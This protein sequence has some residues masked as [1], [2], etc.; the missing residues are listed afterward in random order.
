MAGCPEINRG[1]CQVEHPLTGY[2]GAIGSGP[3]SR[4]T[5]PAARPP[6]RRANQPTHRPASWAVWLV[7]RGS[8]PSAARRPASL[9][10]RAVFVNGWSGVGVGRRPSMLKC[11]PWD[12]GTDGRDEERWRMG[13]SGRHA[14]LGD[15]GRV[16]DGVS[17]VAKPGRDSRITVTRPRVSHLAVP[18]GPSGRPERG[19]HQGRLGQ[20]WVMTGWQVGIGTV[21]GSRAQSKV[22]RRSVRP[23]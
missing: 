22:C 23:G 18:D 21:P 15:L 10:Q 13:R 12:V 6:R 5:C 8:P 3:L 11:N 1:A 9:T 4:G 7:A 17:T 2:E 19:T 14:G 20:P 16:P